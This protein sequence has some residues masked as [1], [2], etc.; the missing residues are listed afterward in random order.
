MIS[1]NIGFVPGGLLQIMLHCSLTNQPKATKM[2]T[3]ATLL[4]PMQTYQLVNWAL[5]IDPNSSWDE[6]VEFDNSITADELRA[7]LL[8]AYDDADTHAWINA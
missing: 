8:E 5:S 6:S 3:L 4:A 2:T 7:A 1:A